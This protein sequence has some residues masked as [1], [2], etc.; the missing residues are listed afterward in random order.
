MRGTKPRHIGVVIGVDNG[1]YSTL[2]GNTNDEGSRDG[3][4][5]CERRRNLLNGKYSIIKLK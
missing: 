2:E 1:L 5:A 4:E 3:Y